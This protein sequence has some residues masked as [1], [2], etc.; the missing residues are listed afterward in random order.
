M[1]G[2]DGRELL[3]LD[4]DEFLRQRTLGPVMILTYIKA[5]GLYVDVGVRTSALN[6]LGEVIEELFEKFYGFSK[7]EALT[8][9]IFDMREHAP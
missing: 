6:E 5:H 1:H 4:A 3:V 9:E 8:W 7:D 2:A